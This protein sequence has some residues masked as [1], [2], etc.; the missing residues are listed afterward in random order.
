MFFSDLGAG[1][2]SAPN[3]VSNKKRQ[4]KKYLS[5][6]VFCVHKSKKFNITEI[7]TGKENFGSI[8]K[9]SYPNDKVFYP[10]ICNNKLPEIWVGSGIRDLEKT[11][12]GSRSQNTTGSR[13][14]IRN[15]VLNFT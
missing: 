3:F 6:L 9:E 10:N 12:P 14:R 8:D 15:T 7:F 4:E 5:Y 1:F 13:V 11:Y 2:F